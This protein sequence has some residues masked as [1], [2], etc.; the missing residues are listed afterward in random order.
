M[1]TA[2]Q[3]RTGKALLFGAVANVTQRPPKLSFL[4]SGPHRIADVHCASCDAR[5]GWAYRESM[6]SAN[7]YKEGRACLEIALLTVE[8][9]DGT[10]Q[11]ESD[12]RN[13]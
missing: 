11:W 4:L 6:S 5:L 10:Q 1:S 7:K 9:E 2:F 3:G 13:L 8:P 12:C